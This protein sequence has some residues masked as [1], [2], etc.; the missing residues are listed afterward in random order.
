MNTN[1]TPT[2]EMIDKAMKDAWYS[3]LLNQWIKNGNEPPAKG[4]LELFANSYSDKKAL[5]LIK[6]S[7]GYSALPPSLQDDVKLISNLRSAKWE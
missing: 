7:K 5:D 1:L 3:C 4:E 6:A 2:P